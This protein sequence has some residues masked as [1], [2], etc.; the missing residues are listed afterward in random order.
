MRSIQSY[1]L[2]CCCF[3]I[4]RSR[5]LDLSAGES[6]L[7]ALAHSISWSSAP[8]KQRRASVQRLVEGLGRRWLQRAKLKPSNN[9]KASIL[10]FKKWPWLSFIICCN[11]AWEGPKVQ[12]KCEIVVNEMRFMKWKMHSTF[13]CFA[14]FP[15]VE[16]EGKPVAF[17]QRYIFVFWRE[18][19]APFQV[20]LKLGYSNWMHGNFMQAWNVRWRWH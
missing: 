4:V 14:C 1:L 15:S 2:K 7:F 19:F 10:F 11:T 17:Y 18:F 16:S 12:I 6:P 13:P 3:H 8:T 9:K 20:K 5:A